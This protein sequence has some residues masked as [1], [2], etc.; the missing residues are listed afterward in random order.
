[1]AWQFF[2][3]EEMA[4]R[5]CGECEMDETFMSDLDW[6][7]EKYGKALR[8]TSG[9]RCA[10]HNATVSSTGRNGPHT[11]GRAADISIERT[12][13]YELSKIILRG[14]FTGVGFAQKGGS[15]F[16]HVDTLQE[17]RPTIWTY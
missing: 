9:F 5:H 6:L 11:T 12:N 17:N 14:P 3:K 8:I 15:R 2:T 16:I 7:R 13:A 1:M 10:D 4:C